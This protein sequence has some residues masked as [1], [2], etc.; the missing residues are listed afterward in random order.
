MLYITHNF[1]EIT[2]AYYSVNYH[3]LDA[4]TLAAQKR[5]I[6]IQGVVAFSEELIPQNALHRSEFYQ[7]P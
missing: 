7:I 4:W 5:D 6:Y 1:S 2:Q 3:Q